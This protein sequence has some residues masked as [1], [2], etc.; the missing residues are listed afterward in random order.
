[1]SR[2]LLLLDNDR[3]KEVNILILND[4]SLLSYLGSD[5]VMENSF[6]FYCGKKL[7]I[8]ITFPTNVHYIHPTKLRILCSY[9][10]AKFQI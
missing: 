4:L 9:Y 10:Y 8:M 6:Y 2:L 1:M 5:V 7:E 3:L